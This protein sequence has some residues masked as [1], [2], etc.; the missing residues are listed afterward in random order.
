MSFAAGSSQSIV[1][2]LLD[3]REAL[4]RADGILP[5]NWLAS[6]R[7][8]IYEVSGCDKRG[9]ARILFFG[10]PRVWG[11]F[12][13]AQSRSLMVDVGNSAAPSQRAKILLGGGDQTNQ[14]NMAD[15]I[16]YDTGDAFAGVTF[17][18][19]APC[20]DA[21]IKELQPAGISRRRPAPPRRRRTVPDHKTDQAQGIYRHTVLLSVQLVL[22][23]TLESDR[24]FPS[25]EL[26]TSPKTRIHPLVL[27]MIH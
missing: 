12:V 11:A 21:G 13:A 24:R 6:Q 9:W 16:L 3:G 15:G 17:P 20:Y 27:R 23:N 14:H 19:T 7:C 1:L 18:A 8:N 25:L 5:V 10:L 2:R 4:L 22:S 26:R